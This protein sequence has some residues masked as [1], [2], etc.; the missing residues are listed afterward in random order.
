MT[1]QRGFC[2]RRQCRQCSSINA[3]SIAWSPSIPFRAIVRC[4]RKEKIRLRE[5]RERER[6][7]QFARVFRLFTCRPRVFRI[8]Q[9]TT[10]WLYHRTWR[11]ASR[12][13]R[14]AA[15]SADPRTRS[16]FKDAAAP[17]GHLTDFS[18]W[19]SCVSSDSVRKKLRP[20]FCGS[21]LVYALSVAHPLFT[22]RARMYVTVKRTDCYLSRRWL[23]CVT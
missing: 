6:E 8:H 20:Q 17:K 10:G 15:I 22:C 4:E 18:V 21:A 12:R 14:R 5:H 1:V 23:K 16:L 9:S 13:A 11:E 3:W 7:R 2:A 19:R